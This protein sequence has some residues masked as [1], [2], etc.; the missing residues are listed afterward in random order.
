MRTNK[1]TFTPL[2]HE[3]VIYNNKQ[4]C[5]INIKYNVEVNY[6]EAD[7]DT[8]VWGFTEKPKWDDHLGIYISDT[9]EGSCV[10]LTRTPLH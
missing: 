2:G 1:V 3:V 7:P 10:E 9:E 4:Y 5:A 6:V 8:T